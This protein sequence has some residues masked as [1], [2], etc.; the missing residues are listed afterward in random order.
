MNAYFALLS[1]IEHG[2]F[3]KAA[4]QLG[5]TQSAIS[6]L[7][8]SLER[9]LDTKLIIRSRTGVTLTPDG[10]EYL[11]YIKNICNT[12]HDLQEKKKVMQGLE[13]GLIKIGTISSIASTF[14]P[15]WIKMFK[16]QYP[17]IKFELYTGDYSEI[18]QMIL[19]GD[20]DFGFINPTVITTLPSIPIVQD[21]M[22]AC[23]HKNNP[24]AQKESITLKQL[25]KEPFI[26]IQEGNRSAALQLF[27]DEKLTP[28]VECISQDDLAVLAMVRRELGVTIIPS[29]VLQQ[30][31]ESLVMRQLSPP[32]IRT[33]SLAF[34][35]RSILQVASR[36]F[37]D[38]I[39]AQVEPYD[40]LRKDIKK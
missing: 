30:V 4:E 27:E 35:D 39:L 36:K 23:V 10:E 9:E 33:I 26:L 22:M 20:V 7:I 8:Q 5:Y 32:R 15:G 29:L 6:Q 38:H 1:V 2:T 34:K 40:H 14:V 12:V 19:T 18:E 37:I 3:T 31:E 24:L 17:N 13:S 21:E 28:K 11:P 16:Q 25:A